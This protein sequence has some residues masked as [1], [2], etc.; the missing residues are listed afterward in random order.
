[1]SRIKTHVKKGDQ[2]EIT[3]GNHKGKRGTVLSVNAAKGQVVIEGGRQVIKAT[4][5]SQTNEKGGLLKQDAPV[6]I[7]NVKKVG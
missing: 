3:T 7:S 1:M 5:P 6:H 2:V 4:R